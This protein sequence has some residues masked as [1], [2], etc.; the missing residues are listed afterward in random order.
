MR[1][2]RGTFAII[3]IGTLV[4]V[5]LPFVGSTA[6][7]APTALAPT[8]ADY[9]FTDLG[10]DYLPQ[11]IN[12]AG[13]VLVTSGVYK[14]SGTW[15][16]VWKDGQITELIPVPTDRANEGPTMSD[17]NDSGLVIGTRDNF[18][19]NGIYIG[20]QP[21]VWADASG[22]GTPVASPSGGA[23]AAQGEYVNDTGAVVFSAGYQL[24]NGI[25]DTAFFASSPSST[26]VE[27]GTGFGSLT[28]Y[29]HENA[30]CGITSTG[31]ILVA[32]SRADNGVTSAYLLP[33]PGAT[34]A[35]SVALDFNSACGNIY[36][37]G[38]PMSK[39]G[40][41]V[42]VRNSD[43]VGVLRTPDGTE[44]VVPGSVVPSSVN[45]DGTVVGRIVNDGMLVKDGLVTDLR[46]LMPT[47]TSRYNVDAREIDNAGDIIGTYTLADGAIRGYILMHKRGPSASFT[48]A[49][50]S[51]EPG[52]LQFVSTSTA[53]TGDVLTEDWDFG[54]GS[55]AQG[56]AVTHAYTNP[57][58]FHVTLKVT[59]QAGTS[60]SVTHDSVIASPT[61][62]S[63]ISFVDAAGSPLSSVAPKVGDVVHY[64]VTLAAGQDGV[65]DLSHVAFVGD[66]LTIAVGSPL[67]DVGDPTP[68]IPTDLTLHPGESASF[69]YSLVVKAAGDVRA[70]TQATATDAGGATITSGQNQLS[71]AI[72]GL[73]VE[74]TLNPPSYAAEPD[75]LG[76]KPVDITVTEKITNITDERLTGLNIR[77]LDVLRTHAGQLLDSQL[78]LGSEAPDPLTGLPF[79]SLAPGESTTFST[80]FTLKSDGH[81]QFQSVVTAASPS[82]TTV[83]GSGSAT[84]AIGVTKVLEFTSRVVNPT[85]A[86]LVPAGTPI[87]I[88]G[89]VHNLT[90]SATL[91]VG[92]LFATTIGN[93]GLQSLTYDGV[94]VSPKAFQVPGALILQPG[95]TKTF[96]LKALTSYSEPTGGGGV[97]RSGGTSATFTFT[98]WAH[99]TLDDGTEYDTNTDGS[100][101]LST[102]ED[103]S[104]RV[105]I[106]DS[107]PIPDYG[108]VKNA[109]IIGGAI[110][111][112]GLEGTWNAASGMVTG[113][114]NLPNV[115]ASTL[116]A[117]VNFQTKVWESFTPEERDAFA[118][119]T[120]YMIVSVLERNVELAKEG[121]PALLAQASDYVENYLTR[122]E[123]AKATGQWADVT[124]IYTSGAA[125]AFGQV[126]IPIAIG[127][128]ASSSEAI[129]ALDASQAELQAKTASVVERSNGAVTA[130]QIAP[131]LTEL[132]TGAELNP[133]EITRLFGITPEELA[134]FQTL[135]T[136]YR[137]LLT[138]RARSATSIDWIEK[139]N[140]AVK[141][142][143]L[144]IKTVSALDTKLGYAAKYEGSL[145]F[146]EPVA[147]ARW[148]AAGAPP[149]A[150]EGFI[151]AYVEEQGFERGTN[152]YYSG[153]ARIKDRV[154]E[155]NKWEATYLQW[156]HQGW[157]DTTFSWNAQDIIAPAGEGPKYDGFNLE[158][159]GD[160]EY[161]VKMYDENLQEYVPV[162]GD[163][164]QVAF[165]HLDGSQLDPN[166]FAALLDEMRNNPL[167]Q[168]QHGPAETYTDG[169]I[170]FLK[171]QF[172]PNEP[173]LQIGPTGIAPRV[174][175]LNEGA[176]NWLSAN[177][178]HIVWDGSIVTTGGNP[179]VAAPAPDVDYN[180]LL[181]LEPAAAQT[182]RPLPGNGSQGANV[183]RCRVVYSGAPTAPL[184]LMNAQGQIS[185]LTGGSLSV[186]PYQ[187][188]CFSSGPIVDVPVK[189]ATVTSTPVTAGTHEVPIAAPGP[190]SAT[191]D[192]SSGFAIGQTVI[193]DPGT[194]E[195][196]RQVISGFGS[197]IFVDGLKY[198][199]PAG[200]TI[201][202]ESSPTASRRQALALA[203]TGLAISEP[204]LLGMLLVLFG[205]S[206]RVI[207]RRRRQPGTFRR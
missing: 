76:P 83:I 90:D 67:V 144:K 50:A 20:G 43:H 126:V 167:I 125:N 10:R 133:T 173:A 175:R 88:T 182:I 41:M 91:D 114:I 99:V 24:Q 168:A 191:V 5:G 23:F 11:A 104:R 135:A 160:N 115:S 17:I 93:A 6:T 183:G 136:K 206:V 46:T 81:V 169:G 87:T 151:E 86:P 118:H 201:V 111:Y 120:S 158:K 55:T 94:G 197:L 193:I 113:L 184:L 60:S 129:S 21:S 150:L 58:T 177:N 142:E 95:D 14:P 4:L 186:S 105:S 148:K 157:V 185:Q 149:E 117:A 107:I 143:A 100:E 1:S 164:D 37:N 59:N 127:K 165:S 19:A 31:K 75:E 38:F 180:S 56:P 112:G 12:N 196:E 8:A 205:I 7:A 18:D 39:N 72:G 154:K 84:L 61:L 44:T 97:I 82:S 77:S 166:E 162:T 134:E 102:A 207:S 64:K 3:A 172:K 62:T 155:W 128:M 54:D 189:P 106:D 45:D 131:L 57:G 71:F 30:V 63:S 152:D 138:V 147:L 80:V 35:Q 124:E 92:P 40:T 170:D 187:A 89:T 65:G 108:T 156:D 85:G 98:P 48:S 73:K 53:P 74:I 188:S 171:S 51:S 194:P 13:Q 198:D 174:V 192:P 130:E 25:A 122:L 179:A 66:P 203:M 141:P 70:T 27:I 116:W 140:A 119:E 78:K 36:N 161:I 159:V 16:G 121:T 163:I 145:V 9:T 69:V 26:P 110:M 200:T 146:K 42:G 47:G 139:F 181:Q 79:G 34:A 176:S 109:A 123:N 68:A 103:L 28:S 178:K 153:V 137:Y 101:I 96:T 132:S 204:L 49:P 2:T 199:H 190:L 32:I 52:V 195:E 22:T 202:V 33:S 15:G 29:A